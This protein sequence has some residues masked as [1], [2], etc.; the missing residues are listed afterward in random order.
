M[1]RFHVEAAIELEDAID[2]YLSKSAEVAERFHQTFS[3]VLLSIETDPQR[4]SRIHL[5]FQFA[6]ITCFP[7]VCIFRKLQDHVQIV[8]V[9]HT[10]RRERYWIDRE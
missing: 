1:I 9:A 4:F 7:Y 8:A 10:S 6:R 2:W 5:D 3:N